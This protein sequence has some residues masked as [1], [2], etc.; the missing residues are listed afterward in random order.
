MARRS[1]KAKPSPPVHLPAPSTKE[2]AEKTPT[3][4]K[5][6]TPVALKSNAK[7]A[8]LNNYSEQPLQN[9]P[10]SLRRTKRAAAG[11]KLET[12][13]EAV[14][15]PLPTAT[16][17]SAASRPVVDDTAMVAMV[18]GTADSEDT[19]TVDCS[20]GAREDDHGHMVRYESCSCW[21]HSSCTGLSVS[22]AESLPTFLCHKCNSYADQVQTVQSDYSVNIA[23]QSADAH[24][25]NPPHS[26]SHVFV[27]LSFSSACSS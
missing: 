12:I 14:K 26:H 11:R 8:R 13:L 23:A 22:S 18:D 7:K 25:T 27:T 9:G 19:E 20:C 15:E 10:P 4:V 2:G 16:P 24:N 6:K 5:A 1:G 3:P 17:V 21:S